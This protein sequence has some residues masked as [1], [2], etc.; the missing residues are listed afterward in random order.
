MAQH[1]EAAGVNLEA[2]YEVV[3]RIKS[4]VK[5]TNRFGSMGN[6]GSFGGM[7]DLSALNIKD[8][9]SF[10][11]SDTPARN[12]NFDDVVSYNGCDQRPMFLNSA[13]P[14]AFLD[15]WVY[16]YLKYP[17]AAL[18]EG[19][20]GRVMVDFIIGKDGKVGFVLVRKDKK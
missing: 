15:K 17:E 19:I 10:R 9:F 3:S 16:Q 14:R 13:D 11:P 2:G 8:G 6:I 7:F 4:H 20:Q 5:S 1:Y 18:M 12:K